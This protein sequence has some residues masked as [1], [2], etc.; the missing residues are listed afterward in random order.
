MK[1]LI[2][3]ST[4]LFIGSQAF[5]QNYNPLDYYFNGT[6]T[7]GIKIK[8]NIPFQN[9][10]TMPS[11]TLEGYD[12]EGANVIDIKLSWYVY[13]D[14]FDQVTASSSGTYV[15]PIKLANENGYVVIFIN[16]W[17]YYTRFTVHAFAVGMSETSAMFENWTAADG[18]TASS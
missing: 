10:L 2:L 8:T 1:R 9:Q 14:A 5:A 6:P 16:D 15:P 11:I 18:T 3:L 7:N 13:Q 17:K 12:F 4:I